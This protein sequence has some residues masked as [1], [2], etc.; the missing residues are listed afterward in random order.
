VIWFLLQLLS[1]LICDLVFT[2]AAV[3][4]NFGICD[5]VFTPAAVKL[6]FGIYDYAVHKILATL[7]GRRCQ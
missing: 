1:N 2:S 6:N 7:S 4:L 5:L 3:K